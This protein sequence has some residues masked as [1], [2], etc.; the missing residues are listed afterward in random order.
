M[1]SVSLESLDIV[2]CLSVKYITIFLQSRTWLNAI[3]SCPWL[4]GGEVMLKS[5]L[6]SVWDWLLLYVMAY[7]R[8]NGNCNLVSWYDFPY[9]NLNLNEMR[10]ILTFCSAQSP[11]VKTPTQY[12]CMAIIWTR[13]L[14]VSPRPFI[15]GVTRQISPTFKMS[16]WSGRTPFFQNPLS[17]VAL[18]IF[19]MWPFG[20]S[21]S[22]KLSFD[23]RLCSTEE[24]IPWAMVF[25]MS[26]LA[27]LEHKI[28]A[29]KSTWPPGY[30]HS[31]APLWSLHN[32]SWKESLIWKY[33]HP[34]LVWPDTKVSCNFCLHLSTCLH[35]VIVLLLSET[36][37]LHELMPQLLLQGAY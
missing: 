9:G 27:L 14:L 6:N 3:Y 37:D 5:T 4:K 16:S 23:L 15:A 22:E 1:K 7:A 31:T 20:S 11:T 17:Y 34:P 10:G 2:S 32:I 19:F 8:R 35:T 33:S 36:G 13:E 24:F 26:T 18:S 30:N 12:L 28:V 29:L 25:H 21:T